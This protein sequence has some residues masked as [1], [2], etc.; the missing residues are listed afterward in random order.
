MDVLGIDQS[1][2]CTGLAKTTPAGVVVTTRIKTSPSGGELGDTRRRIR[3][4]VGQVLRFAPTECVTVIEAPIVIRN[5]QGGAQLERAW[6]FGLLVDQ[7][8]IHGPIAQVRTKTRA[9]YA[10]GN[11]NAD[12]PEVLA[13][14]RDSF[15]DLTVPDDNVADAVALCAMGARWVGAPIDGVPGKKQMAAMVA[16]HWPEVTR[17]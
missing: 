10:T 14:I 9:M 11:G 5:G 13:A 1:L 7:L 6:L 8:I 15:P 16:V 12:K 4:I 3:Y 2:T 17:G